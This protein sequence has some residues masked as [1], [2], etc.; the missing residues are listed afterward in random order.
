[1]KQTLITLALAA[2][3]T[4]ALAGG[5]YDGIYASP[6]S[7]AS[8]VSIHHSD[9]HMIAAA[10]ESTLQFGGSISTELGST[11]PAVLS[12]WSLLGGPFS[13]NEANVTGEMAF[14]ACNI[15][16]RAVFTDTSFQLYP[17]SSTQTEQGR[18]TN[19]RCGDFSQGVSWP[20]T[21]R[22]IF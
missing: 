12:T 10:F 11:S 3:G 19:F 7:N 9:S 18:R 1:M 5:R 15:T 22:R 16:M 17:L 14:G 20:L 13:G 2:I 21:Y 4:S 6:I 8:W